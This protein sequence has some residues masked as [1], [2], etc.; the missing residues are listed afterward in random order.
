VEARQ[1]QLQLAG[2]GVDVA[3]REDTGHAGLELLGV[4]RN[5]VF[6]EIDPPMSDRPELHG[7]PE[8]GKQAVDRKPVLAALGL[9]GDGRQRVACSAR[10]QPRHLADH[11]GNLLLPHHGPHPLHGMGCSAK[12]VP[13]VQQR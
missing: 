8:E 11:K 9:D 12:F 2:V 7:E 13:A 10:V 4:D 5:E 1:D 6:I 3:D